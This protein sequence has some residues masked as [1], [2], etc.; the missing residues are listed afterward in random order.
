VLFNN[1]FVKYGYK[2]ANSPKTF[3]MCIKLGLVQLALVNRYV[4]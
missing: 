1:I 4:R 3:I 2:I